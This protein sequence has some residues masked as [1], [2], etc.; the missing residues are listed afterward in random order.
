MSSRSLS[1]GSQ[2]G[3]AAAERAA[4]SVSRTSNARDCVASVGE[5]AVRPDREGDRRNHEERKQRERQLARDSCAPTSAVA[6]GTIVRAPP[7]AIDARQPQEADDRQIEQHDQCATLDQGVNGRSSTSTCAAAA[8]VPV[9]TTQS[10][11]SSLPVAAPVDTA[12][13]G[14]SRHSLAQ[15]ARCTA[16][17]RPDRRR[18]RAVARTDQCSN[19]RLFGAMTTAVTPPSPRERPSR[20]RCGPCSARARMTGIPRRARACAQCRATRVARDWNLRRLEQRDRSGIGRP[21]R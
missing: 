9:R 17:R 20:A 21:R 13:G 1:A 16:A 3:P 2:S 4:R 6:R 7:S 10:P 19:R 12:G 8:P 5:L 14:I 11:C 18:G 15:A